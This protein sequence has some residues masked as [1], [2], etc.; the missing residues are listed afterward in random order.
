MT[1][2]VLC[3]IPTFRPQQ[4]FRELVA[5]VATQAPV[6]VSDDASPVT[7]DA[8]LREA[9]LTPEVR[10]LRHAEN[11]G[12]A[13]GLNEGLRAARQAGATWL[14]TLDQDSGIEPGYVAAILDAA[15][16][17][18]GI[19]RLGAI[20]AAEVT[21]GDVTLRYPTQERG[22]LVT[23]AEL[24]QTGTLWSVGALE[25][26][27]GFDES[28]G[29]DAVDAAACLRLRRAG[30]ELALAPSVRITHRIGS[31]QA[32]SFL[33]REVLATGHSPQ[34]R[35]TMVRNRLRLLPEELAASPAQG[36]RSLRRLA[37]NTALAVTVED[38]RWAKA[39]GSIRGL[40]PKRGK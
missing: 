7:I 10:V 28:L 35:A 24:V 8:T 37:V 14:L 18:L 2:E 32:V 5:E 12:I 33:G 21:D 19:T 38:D 22:G 11:A 16:V 25:A 15:R 23:T 40:L 26:I 3:V 34:R 17:A 20:G 6:L 27:G 29:I 31:A 39:K 36:L 30:Y 9:S 4:A 13:R 1:T